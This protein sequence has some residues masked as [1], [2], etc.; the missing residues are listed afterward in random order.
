M[1]TKKCSRCGRTLP[2]TDFNWANKAKGKRQDM[3]RECFSEYNRKRYA[4]DPER[5]KR[6]VSEH[7]RR[8]PQAVLRTRLATNAR[9]PTKQNAHK[10]V[11]A[12]L[13]AGA[14]ENPGVCYGC[15]CTS[16]E[17]R[18][19]AH[20]HDYRRPL[21]VVWLCTP[22]HRRMDMARRAGDEANGVSV[23]L[24]DPSNKPRVK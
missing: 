5:F 8:D 3:C 24:T 14:I 11:E 9:N 20:H 16:D 15:G 4:S 2:T 18:I 19:E 6:A 1:E 7:K 10:C 22:C 13:K 21:D 12:A 17:Q 23:P